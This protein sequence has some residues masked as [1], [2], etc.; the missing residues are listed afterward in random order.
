MRKKQKVGESIT[1]SQMEQVFGEY[2]H[3]VHRIKSW[4]A[5]LEEKLTEIREDCQPYI[6]DLKKEE[7]ALFARL[8]LWAEQNPDEFISKKSIETLHG[9]IGFRTGTPKL[10]TLRG[11]T[12]AS[13]LNLVEEFLPDYTRQKTELDKQRL[14][15]HR[16]EI[17]DKDYQ[18]CGMQVVQDE[19][20]F[21]DPK[22]ETSEA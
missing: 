18:K 22:E 8:Q 10:K 1:A 19:A 4:Q 11:Y 7:K 17:D 12:W 20:F 2:V 16:N 15:D 9:V 3:T 21:V 13:V 6:D 14:I 5:N